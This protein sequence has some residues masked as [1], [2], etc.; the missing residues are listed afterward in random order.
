MS[1]AEGNGVLPGPFDGITVVEIGQFVVVPVCAQQLAWGG[2]RVIKVE[3]PEG[4]NYRRSNQLSGNESRAYLAKNRAKESIALQIGSDGADDV[5]R[6]L[7]AEA[8]VVLVNMS[9]TATARHGLDYE[10]VRQ[11][12]P[13][14]IHGS[15]AAFG[16]VGLEAAL[17]GMDGVAQARSGLLF[18]LGAEDSAGVPHHSEVVAADYAA[19]MLLFGGVATALFAR[20]RTG[21]GQ[22]VEVSLLGGALALQGN[23][24]IHL[25]E[26][27]QWRREFVEE[28][29]PRC[30]SERRSPTEI[31]SRREM[32][33]PDKN[34]RRRA[35][36]RVIPTSDGYIAVAAGSQ[37]LKNLLFELTGVDPTKAA[38]LAGITAG[39]DAAVGA[40][41]TAH[42]ITELQRGGIPVA[43]VRHVDEMLFDEHAFAEGLIVEGEHPV[44]GPYRAFGPAVRLSGTPLEAS[45]P[46]PRFAC[47]TLP[48]L[49]ELGYDDAQIAVL[50]SDRA[51]VL[52][53][54]ETSSSGAHTGGRTNLPHDKELRPT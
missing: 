35:T 42:W 20:E 47:H 14:I 7:F 17:P 49:R 22:K 19:A 39:L 54:L 18:A 31:E 10:S 9:P 21:Q 29:L 38:D 51:V 3:P 28:E 12:N 11:H 33:R 44:I 25:E 27:D 40:R 23:A 16:H 4:D 50:A 48:V 52:D 53:E 37:R 36:H 34:E 46:S 24:L 43:E 26:H 8:D 30:R 2:A 1:R 32:F 5:L 13:Q 45:A 15:V 41:P 6:R